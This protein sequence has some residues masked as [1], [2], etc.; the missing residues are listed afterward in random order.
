MKKTLCR[1]CNRIISKFRVRRLFFTIT[2]QIFP[3]LYIRKFIKESR[4]DVE[5]W[6][7]G[8]FRERIKAAFSV[9]LSPEEIN[10]HGLVKKLTEDVVASYV[11]HGAQPEEYFLMGF[12]KC[13]SWR[14]RS[15]FLT[16]K[17]KDEVLMEKIGY[18]VYCRDAKDKY[19]FYQLTQAFFHR[20]VVKV[21][22]VLD[23][24]AFCSFV[25]VHP[26][27]IVKPL[28]GQCGQGIHIYKQ[29][30]YSDI[31]ALFSMLIR[32]GEWIVE[33]LINQSEQMKLWNPQSVNSIRIPSF[34][35]K[36]GEFSI[37]RPFFRT[38]RKGNIVDNGAAGGIFAC[39][40]EKDGSVITN[41][42]DEVGKEYAIHPDSGMR[43]KNF[44]IPCWEELLQVVKKVHALMPVEHLY[45]GFDFAHTPRGWVL[46]EG[47]WGQFL[48]EFAKREGIK[49]KF[50]DYVN[51]EFY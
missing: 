48:S 25:E 10:N 13:S 36:I 3:K 22:T 16:I 29:A 1:I 45:M 47:N 24:T 46:I 42:F 17:A 12:R 34:R 9:F 5:I 15:S 51:G 40:D 41:G 39:I 7:G 2:Q 37:L 49:K 21:Q 20:D 11:F 18:D 19:A 38:G 35:N 4:L 6:G 30:E 32:Q 31:E 8:R 26:N 28:S 23:K 50:I 43:F 44:K 33:E 27:F 14:Y